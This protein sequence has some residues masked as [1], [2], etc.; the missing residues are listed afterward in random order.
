MVER[1]EMNNQYKPGDLVEWRWY[2]YLIEGRVE[3][4]FFERTIRK[5][6]GTEITRNGSEQN[7]AYLVRSDAGNLA[8]K[9]GSELKP[10]QKIFSQ[11]KETLRS[12]DFSYLRRDKSA[13]STRRQH[14]RD[15]EW[16]HAAVLL[17]ID[18]DH[19]ELELRP[20]DGGQC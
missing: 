17:P 19:G 9:L 1:R 6:K 12:P 15:L 8:L 10:R 20:K 4:V 14:L 3:E 5:I 2:S 11:G 7:P 16:A 18:K 13:G